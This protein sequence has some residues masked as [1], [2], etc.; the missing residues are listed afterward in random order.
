[1]HHSFKTIYSYALV[2]LITLVVAYGLFFINQLRC[3][4][5]SYSSLRQVEERIFV[6]P[7]MDDIEVQLLMMNIE[8]SKDRLAL[9]FDTIIAQPVIIAG[10]TKDIM[11][12][13]GANM[14]SPGMN[15]ITLLGTFIVLGPG[16]LNRD[17]ISHELVHSELV[18]R[19][20]W[21]N[22]EAEIPTWFDE[23]L[24]LML[25]YRY[26][27]SETLWLMLTANGKNAPPLPELESMQD[28]MRYT[29]QSPFL[30]YVTAS[31]E[32]TRWWNIVG[33]EGFNEFTSL[34]K[35]DANFGDAYKKIELKYATPDVG[36]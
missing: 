28:F 22:R 6:D 20:G 30:S 2:S 8:Q 27:N 4:M 35:E 12:R 29:E 23:G 19:I 1:M 31:R 18:S 33:L 17:V 26:A 14:K 10:P 16:G 36:K 13:Y 9:F 21:Y 7:E 5:V 34:L 25:D 24:A 3:I 15:H 32:V 11:E